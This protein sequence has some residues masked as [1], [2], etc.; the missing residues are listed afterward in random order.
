MSSEKMR[1]KRIRRKSKIFKVNVICFEL[2]R[3]KFELKN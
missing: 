2:V 3:A 1:E